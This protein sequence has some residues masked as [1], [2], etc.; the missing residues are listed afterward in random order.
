MSERKAVRPFIPKPLL[1]A[2]SGKSPSRYCATI[3]GQPSMNASVEGIKQIAEA[4]ALD[5]I[6][7]GVDQD[8]QENFFHPVSKILAAQVPGGAGTQPG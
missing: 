2:S 8:A 1:S 7:L 4:R 3:S 5:V 6:S